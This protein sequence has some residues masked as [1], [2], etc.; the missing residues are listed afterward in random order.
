MKRKLFSVAVA[1]LLFGAI[2]GPLVAGVGYPVIVSSWLGDGAKRNTVQYQI[3]IPSSGSS[4][5]FV[6][7]TDNTNPLGTSSLRFSD[8]QTYDLTAA[9][10]VVV[11]DDLAVTDD[12]TAADITV[13]GTS[14]LARSSFGI[15]LSSAPKTSVTLV[16]NS[17]GTLVYNTADLELCIST[18][19]NQNSFVVVGSMTITC[20]H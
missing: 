11:S 19:S 13:T 16:F 1:G 4:A 9:D 2:I 10:D 17:T 14:T 7:G 18:S 3:R 8:V 20:T 6:P 5:Q 12:I 15:Q